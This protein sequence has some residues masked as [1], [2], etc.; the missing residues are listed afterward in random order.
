MRKQCEYV[1]VKSKWLTRKETRKL[2]ALDD[3]IMPFTI[4][5]IHSSDKLS[6]NT[7]LY[8]HALQ[9]QLQLQLLPTTKLIYNIYII[10]M[11]TIYYHLSLSLSLTQ[12][13]HYHYHYMYHLSH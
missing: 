2:N 3:Y 10:H 6:D 1:N 11:H 13:Y 12:H 7:I 9:L 5:E 8:N 4:F